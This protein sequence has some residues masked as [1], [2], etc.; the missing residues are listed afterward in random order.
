MDALALL[1]S[2][3]GRVTPKPFAIAVLFIYLAGFASQALLSG[4]LTARAGLWPFVL[5]QAVLIWSWIALHAKRLRDADREIGAAIGIAVVYGLAL[6]LMLLVIAF[7][8]GLD[9]RAHAE[10]APGEQGP[11]SSFLVLLLILYLF[12]MLFSPDFG[13]VA[14]MLLTLVLLA[15]LPILIGFIFSIWAGTRP[16]APAPSAQGAPVA[17]APSAP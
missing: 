17:N 14:W 11:A 15:F 13:A 10:Q 7:F 6:I 2:A 9:V 4:P 12:G 1:F 16:S 3:S 8:V 5:V